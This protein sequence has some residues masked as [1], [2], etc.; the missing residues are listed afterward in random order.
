[1]RVALING[2]AADGSLFVREGRCT[3]R[4]SIWA[5][6][7]PPVTLAYLA[8]V[9]RRD[10]R[11]PWL[12][13]C[14]ATG[15]GTSRLVELLRGVDPKVGVFA[16][17]TPSFD[18]DMRVIAVIRAALPDLSIA[19]LGAHATAADLDLLRGQPAVDYVIRHEPEA[20]FAD[21]LDHLQN[22][23]G[24]EGV[25][26]LSWRDATGPR[27][28]PPRPFVADLDALPFPAWDLIDLPRYR[29][30]FRRDRFLSVVPLRG[31]PYNCSFCT[32]GSYYG[33]QVRLR[34][35]ASVVAEVRR[36]LAEFRVRDFFVWAETFTINRD[37]VLTVCAALQRDAPG[38]RWTCNSRTD[39]VDAPLLAAMRG[40]G[41]WLV[42]FG[43]EST[44][45]EVL[46]R[47]G[48]NPR[49][50]DAAEVVRLARR[51]GIRTLGHFI[52][53]LPGDTPATVRQTMR[54]ARAMD[55]DFA[56]FYVAA[57][58]VGS[59]LYDQ[60]RREGWLRTT[61]FAALNQARASLE[62]PRLPRREIDRLR[63]WAVLSFYCHPRR[64]WRVGRLAGF[65]MIRQ[66]AR[67][68]RR[69]W[70]ARRLRAA[71]PETA[72]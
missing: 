41:C 56:Q 34:S 61:E 59:K 25:P 72:P 54:D 15:I 68:A 28:N 14:P 48:K 4:S 12:F 60:A 43:I 50:H 71:G 20:S 69:A 29:L 19:V 65:G 51:A 52:L 49:V 32:A 37:F 30:P 42:G 33:R 39:T 23:Q 11:Q 5:A 22:K 21:L 64:I 9:A 45:A 57:P 13:D 53:G 58:F 2:P 31:C 38:I 1:V 17:S 10:G 63:A 55:L 8:A 35:A 27:R 40:A 18:V 16:V 6:Q 36:D 44:N 47:T 66:L 70:T 46:A 67:Q 62:L 24:L 26:G 3:Q 7:W